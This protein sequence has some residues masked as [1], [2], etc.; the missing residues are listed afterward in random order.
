MLNLNA[1]GAARIDTNP[2]TMDSDTL[3][4]TGLRRRTSIADESWSGI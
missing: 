4:F 2:L 1:A 3:R